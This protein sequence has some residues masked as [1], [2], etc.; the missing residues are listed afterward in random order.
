MLLNATS[1]SIELIIAVTSF[2]RFQTMIA[3][4]QR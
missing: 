4:K 1:L 3:Q 2:S